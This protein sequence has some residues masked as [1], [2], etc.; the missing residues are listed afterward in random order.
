MTKLEISKFIFEAMSENKP[1][2]LLP[3]F[4]TNVKFNFPG[5]GTITGNRMVAR[6]I[7][8]IL[9]RYNYLK[10]YVDKIVKENDTYCVFWHN[11][12]ELKQ[13]KSIY[14]NVGMTLIEFEND[15]VR[16]LS[17]YFKDTSFVQ[18]K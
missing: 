10:F 8:M 16:F 5:I 3:Y 1:A 14:E 13:D 2:D 17:D 7:G 15:K 4:D 12:G 18:K 9:K 6:I 11:K